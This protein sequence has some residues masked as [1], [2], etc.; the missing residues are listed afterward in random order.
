LLYN[1]H[2]V[3]AIHQQPYK[4][5]KYSRLDIL[6]PQ[7]ES[8]VH[9]AQDYQDISHIVNNKLCP[10]TKDVLLDQDYRIRLGIMQTRHLH[11]L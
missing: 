5:V 10:D 8:F 7:V 6:R 9:G 2:I 4:R 11:Y 1:R 3:T